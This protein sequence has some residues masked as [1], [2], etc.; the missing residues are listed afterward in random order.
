M[1]MAAQACMLMWRWC[2]SHLHR[3]DQV[4]K[5]SIGIRPRN[6]VHHLVRFEQ[7]RLETLGH[8]A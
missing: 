3:S 1:R 6:Q 5:V 8:A 2:A 7:L 4:R